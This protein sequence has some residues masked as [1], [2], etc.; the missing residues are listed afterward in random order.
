MTAAPRAHASWIAGTD[1]RMRVSSA[2][3]PASSWGTFKSA[4]MKTRLPR[5]STSESRSNFIGVA[6]FRLHQRN[7][8]VQ[9]STAETPFVVVPTRRF[10]KSPRDLRQRGVKRSEERRVGKAWSA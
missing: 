6:L 10:D 1:A 8:D 7:G 9:H 2:M 3:F 5:T 4:R